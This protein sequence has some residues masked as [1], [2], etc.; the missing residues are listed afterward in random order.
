MDRYISLLRGVN[1]GK[2]NKVNML[3]LK[4]IYEKLGFKRVE[5]YIQSGNVLFESPE[6]NHTKL[7][8]KI[9]DGIAK[10]F[11]FE[12]PVFIRTR[13]E[14]QKVIRN[15]PFA[16][17][18][19]NAIYVTFLSNALKNAAVD[20]IEKNKGATEEYYIDDREIYLYYPDGYGKTKLSNN[21]FEKKLKVEATTRNWKTVNALFNMA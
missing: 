1:L 3:R 4:G 20:E 5:T 12:V 2:H 21:F 9:E 10:S 6:K 18:D 19:E 11:G 15:N 16:G 8:L 7:I 17:R 13:V 14:M